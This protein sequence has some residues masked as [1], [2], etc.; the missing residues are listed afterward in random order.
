MCL[1]IL[2]VLP[3]VRASGQTE[4][5]HEMLA[6]GTLGHNYAEGMYGELAAIGTY[7]YGDDL[8]LRGGL[9]CSTAGR[10][11]AMTGWEAGMTV[12]E[13][14]LWFVTYCQWRR[15]A[16]WKTNEFCSRIGLGLTRNGWRVQMGLA[17]RTMTATMV[18]WLS[19]N[20]DFLSEPFNF[21]YEVCHTW[22]FGKDDEWMLSARVSD[23]DDFVIDRAYQPLFSVM[24]RWKVWQHTELVGRVIVHPTG[25]LSLSANYYEFMMNIGVNMVW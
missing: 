1:L 25:M 11:E 23:F 12:G 13:C 7:H 6:Y 3:S 21:M 14:R 15:F 9:E 10:L 17:R 16:L 2:F 5:N 18:N 4:R 24:G 19:H 8:A 22:S 20:T